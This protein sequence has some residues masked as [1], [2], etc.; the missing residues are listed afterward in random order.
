MNNHNLTNQ[1]LIQELQSRIDAGKIEVQ[2]NAN[3]TETRSYSLLSKLG[4]KEWLLLIG[5]SVAF[6]FL[7]CSS[8]KVTTTLPTGFRVE[9]QENKNPVTEIWNS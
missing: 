4:S 8:L 9:L 2:V 1:E 6:T 5:L 3:E 7:I